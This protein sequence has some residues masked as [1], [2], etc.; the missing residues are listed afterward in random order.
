MDLI[1]SR[2]L[3]GKFFVAKILLV[4]DDKQLSGQLKTFLEREN[5]AVELA[6]DGRTGLELLRHYH[7]DLIILDWQMPALSG[8]EVLKSF[9]EHGGRSPV[10]MLTGRA[11]VSDKLQGF[12]SGA[13]DYLGK[14]FDMRELLARARLLLRRPAM[15]SGDELKVRGLILSLSARKLSKNGVEIPLAKKEFALLELLMRN[16]NQVFSTT[17]L[18]DRIWENDSD[19]TSDSLRTA[20][21]KLRKKIDEEGQES[22]I[23]NL[24][25]VGYRLD[26]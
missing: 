7:Y 25:G 15:D 19:A 2:F 6:D 24:P 26:P 12:D 13:D 20:V 23:R 3:L 17:A 11:E 18:L 21:K 10:I 8:L 22:L 5:Y 1:H 4:D 14:P 16:P 9:R